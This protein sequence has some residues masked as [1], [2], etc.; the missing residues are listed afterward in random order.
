M[1]QR[2]APPGLTPALTA[3]PIPVGRGDKTWQIRWSEAGSLRHPPP[4]R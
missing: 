1:N 4:R 2:R 3:V